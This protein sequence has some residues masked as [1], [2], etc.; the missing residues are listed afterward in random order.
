[1]WLYAKVPFECGKTGSAEEEKWTMLGKYHWWLREKKK[2]PWIVINVT[3]G[4]CVLFEQGLFL[5]VGL[6]HL[7]MHLPFQSVTDLVNITSEYLSLKSADEP[8]RVWNSLKHSLAAIVLCCHGDF[9]WINNYQNKQK[10][11]EPS[12]ART[13]L[14]L[15]FL[16]LQSFPAPWNICP[17]PWASD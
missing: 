17:V 14:N 7:L 4:E 9:I 15:Q 6:K 2:K 1:M 11:K 16:S 13:S 3:L 8:H 12:H 10:K 5:T